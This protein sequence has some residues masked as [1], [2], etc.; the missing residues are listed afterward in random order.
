MGRKAT[1]PQFAS[2]DEETIKSYLSWAAVALYCAQEHLSCLQQKKLN[3]TYKQLI[4]YIAQAQ[5]WGVYGEW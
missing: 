5:A 4:R 2:E 1:E 3:D